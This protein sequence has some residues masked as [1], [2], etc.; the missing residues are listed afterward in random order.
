LPRSERGEARDRA[1]VLRRMQKKVDYL[2]DR[3]P[4][5][6]HENENDIYGERGAQ[7]LDLLRSIDSPKLRCAFD[8]ANFVQAG[9]NPLDNWPSLKPYTVHIHIKDALAGTGKVVPAGHGDG[10]IAEIL[11]DACASG[12][13]G[14]LSLEPHLAQ[15]GQFSGFSG[16]DQFKVAADALKKLCR[17][18]GISLA[19]D[20]S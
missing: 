5:L 19:C 17:D 3:A 2:R 1:E 15:H 4:V 13:A 8:F 20:R 12:Y 9:E 16:P 7:C 14:F 10:K 11:K 6:L 18:N